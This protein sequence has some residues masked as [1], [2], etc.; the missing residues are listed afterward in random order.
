MNTQSQRKVMEHGFTI[1][2]IDDSPTIRIKYKNTKQS[3]WSTLET[4]STK[5]SRN[6][7]FKSLLQSPMFI[8]D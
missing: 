6:R 7:A 5:A 4:Y 8:E 1:L 3:E 2:R